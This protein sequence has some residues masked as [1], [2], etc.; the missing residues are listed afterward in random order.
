[1]PPPDKAP[2]ASMRRARLARRARLM[3][4][5]AAAVFVGYRVIAVFLR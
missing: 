4:G 1:M 2:P 5:L 3:L